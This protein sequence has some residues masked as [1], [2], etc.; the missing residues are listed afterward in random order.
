M[1]FSFFSRFKS[2][3]ILLEDI[4]S[5]D[6]I[7]TIF[8]DL[9][10]PEDSVYLTDFVLFHH[11]NHF[12]I[13]LL[14]FLPHYGLYLGEKILWNLQELKGA[15]VK[16][17]TRQSHAASHTQLESTEKI[18]YQKLQDVLSFDAT[19]IERIFWMKNLTYAEFET[20]SPSFHELLPRGRL[21]FKDDTA[22][23][24]QNKLH[25]LREY[26]TYAFSKLKVIGSLRAHTLV[27]PTATETFGSFL[28]PEQLLFLDTPIK[29]RSTL[30]LSAP[31][32][33]GK[34][35]VLIRKVMDYLLTHPEQSVL[36]MTPTRLSGELL[37][38]EFISLMEF[39]AVKCN[40]SHLH[41]YTPSPENESIE[42]T[43]I[44]LESSLIVCD[45]V[46]LLSPETLE[47]V[48][49]HKGSRALLLCGVT[50]PIDIHAN[51]LTT[52]YRQPTVHTVHFTHTKGALFTLLTGLKTHLETI[53]S[54]LIMIILPNHEIFLE[55]KKAIEDHLKVNCRILNDTF[56]LQ[57]DN[58][59]EIT[60][61]T[62]EYISGL[63]VP[64]SYLINLNHHDLLYYPLALS[65]AS[66]TVT[67]ISE[68]NLEG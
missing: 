47:R 66:D 15:S 31:H 18:I 53:N 65:R 41:F 21:I 30:V 68:S 62:P 24:I 5:L 56:S 32:S 14:L 29:N 45:D 12:N 26:Q 43:R 61:S 67:I 3:K 23:D 39:A 51:T 54:N 58:L 57:Y 22:L 42:T 64:H 52:I 40:L 36:V 9:T 49:E 25:A 8:D 13:D 11:E 10:L 60:L 4:P 16:R 59:E 6:N 46:H 20:L 19:P 38:N 28:S 50:N 63:N 35:T 17:L 33:S 2:S 48:I 34:S 55:Y 1:L 7:A 27:L 44:F 37:R